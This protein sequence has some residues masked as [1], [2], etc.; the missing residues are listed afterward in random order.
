LAEI[1]PR[2]DILIILLEGGRGE[3]SDRNA[4][5]NPRRAPQNQREE[6]PSQD[7][8]LQASAHL[9]RESLKIISVITFKKFD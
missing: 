1:S 4:A 6:L 3:G 7:W 9:T 5:E 8:Y 2:I